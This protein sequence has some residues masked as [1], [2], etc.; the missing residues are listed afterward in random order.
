MMEDWK[1]KDDGL[2]DM[3]DNDEKYGTDGRFI[4]KA[5]KVKKEAWMYKWM[6]NEEWND[7]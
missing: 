6:M 7:G 5:G 4:I 3:M 1:M 2:K